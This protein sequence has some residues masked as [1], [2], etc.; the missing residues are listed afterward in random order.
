MA[1]TFAHLTLIDKL[2]RDAAVLDGIETLAPAM[3]GDLKNFRPFCE[4][5]AISPDAPYLQLL[6]GDASRWGNV[7]HDWKTADF[8]RHAIPLVFNMDFRR[9]ETQKC[10]AWLFGYAAHLD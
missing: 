6:S 2:C 5:G 9:A 4:L 3:K 7:M 1:G 8:V 10:L